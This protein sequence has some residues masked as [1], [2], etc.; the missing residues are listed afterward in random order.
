MS[1]D[2]LNAYDLFKN[3]TLKK[4]LT[5]ACVPAALK[6][7]SNLRY[8][9]L[10]DD[11]KLPVRYRSAMQRLM[12]ES[13]K[14]W[15]EEENVREGCERTRRREYQFIAKGLPGKAAKPN[16]A[17]VNIDQLPEFMQWI[18]ILTSN[19]VAVVVGVK[20]I[21]RSF[22][23]SMSKCPVSMVLSCPDWLTDWLSEPLLNQ[24]F[25]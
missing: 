19:N 4:F 15:G 11:L 17:A 22:M 14:W 25:P 13:D 5:L 8:P 1:L 21:T 12:R 3:L 6:P 16:L 7:P 24:N 10:A 20:V 23:N 2:I 9:R 18:F